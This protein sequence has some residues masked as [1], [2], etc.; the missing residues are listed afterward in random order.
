MSSV[1][2]KQ[3]L[4]RKPCFCHYHNLEKFQTRTKLR[5][6][7]KR[8]LNSCKPQIAFKSQ[9]ELSNVF[10]FQ[11]ALPFDLVSGVVYKYINTPIMVIR[12]D[13]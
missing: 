10:R 8:L 13:T 9:R 5:K 4:R 3:Q 2:N 12:I 7:F 6:S 11:D 1:N